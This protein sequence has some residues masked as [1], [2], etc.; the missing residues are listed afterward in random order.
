MM[1]G[2]SESLDPR[3]TSDSDLLQTGVL[4]L[5][6]TAQ[7][8]GSTSPLEWAVWKWGGKAANLCKGGDMMPMTGIMG[9]WFYL[10]GLLWIIV[11]AAVVTA[12]WRGMLAQ[13]RMGRQLEEIARSLS[14][15]PMT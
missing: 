13:E 3:F 7:G 9:G 2:S 14:Q 4:I 15:R 10:Y 11:V 1:R 12:L 6:L 8:W 5:R